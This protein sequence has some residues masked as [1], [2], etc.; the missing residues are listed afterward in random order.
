M[1]VS[2]VLEDTLLPVEFS[3]RD[4]K[5]FY[6]QNLDIVLQVSGIK[7]FSLRFKDTTQQQDLFDMLASVYKAEVVPESVVEKKRV[8]SGWLF[9]QEDDVIAGERGGHRVEVDGAA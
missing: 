8:H 9:A 2:L 7:D 3:T 1:K 4:I 5:T 6:T